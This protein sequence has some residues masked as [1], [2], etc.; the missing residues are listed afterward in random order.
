M[1][2]ITHNVKKISIYAT[3]YLGKINVTYQMLVD[4]FGKPLGGSGDYKTD[5][6]W[7]IEFQGLVATIY[8][9]KN[10]PAYLGLEG[11]PVEEITEWHIGG[12]K[13]IVIGLVKECLALNQMRESL[14]VCRNKK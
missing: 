12:H 10:G 9:Y 8:N 11:T 1:E 6:E 3:N 4:T 7:H 14:A 5:C 2:F 13:K